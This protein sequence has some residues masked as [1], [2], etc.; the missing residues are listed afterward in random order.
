LRSKR[1]PTL[2][3]RPVWALIILFATLLSPALARADSPGSEAD[4]QRLL[5]DAS[6][7][8]LGLAQLDGLSSRPEG[9]LLA[10]DAGPAPTIAAGFQ[11]Y[12]SGLSEPVALA[13]PTARL[14][15]SYTAQVP[16]GARARIDV[17]GSLDGR[18][19]LPWLTHLSSGAV[20]AFPSPVRYA[21]YR[22]ALLGG[23][24][25]S[26][27]VGDVRLYETSQAPTVSSAAPA[28]FAV[29]PTFRV[30]ATR[31]GMVG[32]RTANGFIIPPRA[33]FVS[34]PSWSVLSTR[35]RDE[36]QVRISYKGR[37]SVVPVYDVGPYSER[38]DYWDT[39]RDGYPQLDR[40]WPMD[41]AAYYEGYNGGQADKG[42]VRFPTA[43]DVGDG[44]WW[45]E[46][47]ING[48]QAE[49]EVTY[50]WLG[51][52]PHAGPPARDPAAPEHLVDELGGDFWQSA[53]ALNASAVGC[54]MGRHAYW[55]ASTT[56]ANAGA[57][58]ARWQPNLPAE[59]LY[60]LYVHVPVCPAKRAP[61]A[62]AR[63]VVQHRDGV[64]ELA[65][66]QQ[67]PGW[68]L[69][70]RFPF[71]AGAEGF[72]QLG[73]LAGDSGTVWFDQARWVRVP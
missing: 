19:W 51:Q 49:V 56:D 15:L 2:R 3:S 61:V 12:G 43:I 48:D 63:Y 35:G 73:G 72:L 6:A 14:R 24:V 21:Q 54:G 26:P 42:Y 53:A 65:V 22:V 32:G 27:L 11:R 1:T 67:Q 30:R 40:G 36:Y 18:R 9:L 55:A 57:P 60:D 62:Q 8:P 29:A 69:I 39:Q 70:G 16:P 31:Q 7:P 44:V 4:T 50:L 33:R 46:L 23:P 64:V 5:T 68:V 13:T 17:R 71:R 47:G 25:E 58:V 37:S 20:I 38:D 10:A 52:D 45:D 34:L 41:H 28:P 66:S 59:A